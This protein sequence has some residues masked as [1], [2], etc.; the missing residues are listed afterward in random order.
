MF[1]ITRDSSGRLLRVEPSPFDDMTGELPDDDSEVRAWLAAQ[2]SLA[3]LRQSDLEMVRVLE[4]LIHALIDKGL[5]RIT[6]LPGSAQ[7]KLAGRSRARNALGSTRLLID[8]DDTG[9]I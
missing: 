1:Y 8:D 4:D 6:D 2:D 9:V 3:H 5:L 7:A